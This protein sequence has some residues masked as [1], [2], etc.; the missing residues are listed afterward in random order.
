M[1]LH[2]SQ[3]HIHISSLCLFA[4]LLFAGCVPR[5][6]EKPAELPTDDTLAI[7]TFAGGCF[8]CMETPFENLPGVAAVIS[9]YA[10][11]T[12]EHPTYEEVSAGVLVMLNLY[13]YTM[14]Q[15]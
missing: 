8:W 7:A 13:K 6:Q 12:K 11:G 4:F 9:G 3:R 5:S 1:V 14:I 2:I 15:T 10:G